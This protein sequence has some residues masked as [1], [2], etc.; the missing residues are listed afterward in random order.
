MTTQLPRHLAVAGIRLAAVLTAVAVSRAFIRQTL[1]TW[2]LDGSADAA[3]LVASELVTNAVKSTGTTGAA[4]EAPNPRDIRADHLIGVQLRLQDDSLFVEVWDRGDGAPVI[5][6][7]SLTAE[8]GRGLFLVDALASCWDTYH[9]EVGG[10]IVWA[11]LSLTDPV[12]P[13]ALATSLP[14]S[15]PGTLGPVPGGI[16]HLSDLALMQRLLDGLRLP[17]RRDP[18]AV[19]V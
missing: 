19:A 11:Q 8:G 10:K 16:L 15:A 14:K 1:S 18:E 3:E 6:E 5:P 4:A 9:P 2:Q 13:S 7:Q 12:R 17:V